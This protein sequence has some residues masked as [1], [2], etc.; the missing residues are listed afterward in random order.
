MPEYLFG[1]RAQVGIAYIITGTFVD[2]HF[3]VRRPYKGIAIHKVN[4]LAILLIIVRVRVVYP[5]PYE[6]EEVGGYIPAQPVWVDDGLAVD[7]GFP[8][9]IGIDVTVGEVAGIAG[10]IRS[11]L[12]HDTCI[13]VMIPGNVQADP[14]L[15]EADICAEFEGLSIRCVNIGTDCLIRIPRAVLTGISGVQGVGG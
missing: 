12:A 4:P 6:R 2:D 14:V 10:G 7:H 8:A 15:Q 1:G 11:A 3:T 5:F 9:V 13:P